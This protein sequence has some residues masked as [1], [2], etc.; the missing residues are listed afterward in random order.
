MPRAAFALFILAVPAV[1]EPVRLGSDRFRQVNPVAAI[2]YSPDGKQ[3]ATADGDSVQIWD[4]ADGRRVRTIRIKDHEV[5]SVAFAADG[6]ALFAVTVSEKVTYLSRLDPAAGKPI[7]TRKLL[8]GEATGQFSPDG[9][10]LA[11]W[12]DP[13][14][15][16]RV[17]D[18]ATATATVNDRLGNRWARLVWTA[19]S[20]SLAAA[21][22]D[23]D[24]RV[25]DAA[26]GKVRHTWRLVGFAQV[27]A[28]S[29]D[30]KELAAVVSQTDST[31]VGRFDAAT[32]TARWKHAILVAHNLVFAGDGKA[33]FW[34]GQTTLGSRVRWHGL[35][36]ATGRPLGRAPETGD[37]NAWT[38]NPAGNVLAIGGYAGLVSLWDLTTGKRLD[39][40][41]DP[42]EPVT[43]LRFSPDGAKVRGWAGGWYE[44]D[45]AT[46]KQT[47]L[48]PPL[49]AWATERMSVSEDQRWLCRFVR[50]EGIKQSDPVGRFELID[51]R[52]GE[53]VRALDGVGWSDEVRFLPSGGLLCRRR[54][55]LTVLDPP[56]GR[57]ATEIATGPG[58]SVVVSA[59]GTL[60]VVVTQTPEEARVRVYDLRNGRATA[61]WT[62]TVRRDGVFVVEYDWGLALSPDNRRL[63]IGF[64]HTFE[65]MRTDPLFGVFDVRTGRRVAEWTDRFSSF[66]HFST[67]GRT[68]AYRS[69]AGIGLRETATGRQRTHLPGT[70]YEF[71]GRIAPDGMRAAV[72][73]DP[74]PVEI[75]DLTAGHSATALSDP[76]R[77][78]AALGN[79][80]AGPA[81]DVICRLRGH[82]AEAVA[83]LSARMKV[84]TPPAT[85]WIAAR[86][87]DL[88]APLYRDREKATADLAAVIELIGPTLAA[89]KAT[90]TTEARERLTALLAKAD[91]L[92]PDR[93]RAVR[94]CEVLEGVNTLAARELLASWAKGPAGSTLAREATESLER[95]RRR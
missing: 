25:Y 79:E 54:T 51:L 86:I 20:R 13:D 74:G 38:L 5:D 68:V 31:Y 43:D 91:A 72:S 8:A 41:A 49:D 1:A 16:L 71:D 36:A 63:M 92:T 32:G 7:D 64:H 85:E 9:R 87:K 93:L 22:T 29:P 30:G 47:R 66:E 23:G 78:W 76:D 77:S 65:G 80:D 53:R 67:D 70:R 45:V 28:F 6:K 44:W 81:F 73:V 14:K 55:K 33:I 18:T 95:L 35:D 56:T 17:I 34:Q 42:P 37:V 4:A 15:D 69:D 88:D 3:L 26:A 40:S 60:A 90:A 59:D 89:A 24:V 57:P 94:A 46:G 39:A 84:P 61:E 50:D 12:F 48:T 11:V 82:P 2:A 27:L 10:W 83:F 21:T 52:A 75:W 62:G 58:R 19:D